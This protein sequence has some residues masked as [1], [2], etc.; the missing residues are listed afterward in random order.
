MR[1]N[2]RKFLKT[3]A[4]S[5]A[6]FQIVPRHVIGGQ[7]HT[8]PSETYGAALIGCGGRGPGTYESMVRKLPATLV[9][10][11]DVQKTRVD[12]YIKRKNPEAK[13]YNDFRRLLE[14]PDIDLVA[15]ATPPHWHALIS[16]AAAEAGKD[17]FCEKPM[18]RFIAEGRAV[19]EAFNRYK[20]VFQI[21]TNGRFGAYKSRTSRTIHKIM[22]SGLLKPNPCVHIKKG[23]LKL[24]QW[25][26]K[27]GLKPQIPSEDLDWDLYCGPS[28]LKPFVTDRVGGTHRNYW[29]YEGGGMCD[30]GQHHF[31]PQQWIYGK[32]D[33]SPVKIE[34]FAPP[35]HP[36]VTGM[37]AWVELTYSDGFTF[38]MDS[39][40]WGPGY[41][42][43]ASKQVSLS[44]LSEEDQ[45]KIAAMPDP[46]PLL[47][48]AEAV[49]QRKQA[50][51]HPEAA[52]RA[53]CILHLA[54]IAIRLGRKLQYDPEKEQFVGDDE[55]NRFVNVPMRSP[56]HL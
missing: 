42:K 26:G 44:Q 4:A 45:Q 3:S 43:K 10:A 41:D 35:A 55:A 30:M 48:F 56:W 36:D 39:A 20:R 52:H 9:A 28:P 31:D 40:E 51:G 8:P 6:S 19:V 1:S 46:A 21:G 12:G 24:N 25:S 23:G 29:D 14:N 5:A 7:G 2:R 53:A 18:T 33:T 27:P 32:D 49:K 38:V 17:V 11:C 47:S 15:I 54:N 22:R 37:W 34:A 16:I 50:G 13:G